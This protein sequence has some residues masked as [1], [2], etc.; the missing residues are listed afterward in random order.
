MKILEFSIQQQLGAT[1]RVPRWAIAFKYP[2]TQVTT[3][4]LGITWQVG[5]SGK[6]TPVAELEAVEVAGSTVRRATLHN[7]DELARLGLKVGH[8]VFIEKGGDVIPKVVALVP[9]EETR[10]LPAPIIP[11]TCPAAV[12]WITF[13]GSCRRNCDVLIRKG[14][15][16]CCRFLSRSAPRAGGVRR[17]FTRCSTWGLD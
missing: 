12:L 8:R 6:L 1:D 5:R 15:G 10:D 9:G 11:G 4:V 17:S 14:R 13:R 7:A 2:A 16:R 3:T